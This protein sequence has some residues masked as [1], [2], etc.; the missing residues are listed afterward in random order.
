VKEG[1]FKIVIVDRVKQYRWPRSKKQRIRNKWR[2][3]AENFRPMMVPVG[4]N[5]TLGAEVLRRREDGSRRSN[6]EMA[7]CADSIRDYYRNVMEVSTDLWCMIAGLYPE[8]A[9]RCDLFE[10]VKEDQGG[11]KCDV[12]VPMYE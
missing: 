2:K 10:R 6:A 7:L 8:F 9:E 5:F 4:V 12:D 3:R 11:L 1:R